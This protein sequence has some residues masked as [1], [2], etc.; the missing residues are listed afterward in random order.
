VSQF[1]SKY[2]RL[3][4]LVC[5]AAV[6]TTA[7][8]E[9]NAGIELMFAVSHVGHFLL[10]GQ[11]LGIMKATAGERGKEG[12]IVIVGSE[13]HGFAG[14]LTI[15]QLKNPP[16]FTLK[17]SMTVYGRAKLCNFLFA[18]E[19]SNRL[20]GEGK[21]Q[22]EEREVGR[23]TVNVVNPGA[24]DTELGRETPWYLGWIVKPISRLFF[25]TAKDGA[26]TGLW[27]CLSEKIEGESGKYWDG[28]PV[29]EKKP[30]DYALSA[31]A[32]RE[33]WDYTEEL[34]GGFEEIDEKEE[35]KGEE[36]EGEPKEKKKKKKG[37]SKNKT[38]E[39]D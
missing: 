14:P 19:L 23:V 15:D 17:N 34:T 22:E 11:L 38:Q 39:A 4:R 33:L 37:K 28:N 36:R 13:A 31:E 18:L 7:Y 30:K 12:R 21:Q 24:V 6:V 27:A 26:R 20:K 29:K 8:R 10:V 1:K 9:N 3:D 16:K 5:N 25:K 32:A 35:D 2:S